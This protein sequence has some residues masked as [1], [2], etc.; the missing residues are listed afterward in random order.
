MRN[1]KY[2]IKLYVIVA[3]QLGLFSCTNSKT[4]KFLKKGSSDTL[5]YQQ[6]VNHLRILDSA[7]HTFPDTV[8]HCCAKS[9]D[10]LEKISGIPATSNCS[11]VGRMF[12]TKD[13]L[14]RWHEWFKTNGESLKAGSAI[15]RR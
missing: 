2:Y 13:N 7:A 9:V 6:Y 8:I 4:Q 14:K 10:F 3:L 5:L 15:E 12:F 1:I 11:F